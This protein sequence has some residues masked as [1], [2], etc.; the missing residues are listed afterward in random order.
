MVICESFQSGGEYRWRD[1][2]ER[3]GATAF[4]RCKPYCCVSLYLIYRSTSSG[5]ITQ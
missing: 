4:G 5:T 2:F 1:M 3:H